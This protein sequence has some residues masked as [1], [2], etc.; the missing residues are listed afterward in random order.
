[1]D[2]PHF[3]EARFPCEMAELMHNVLIMDQ[4]PN[5]ACNEKTSSSIVNSHL[6]D[7]KEYC[8]LLRMGPVVPELAWQKS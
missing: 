2:M 1:M 3:K 4:M 5:R 8:L 7:I 6:R